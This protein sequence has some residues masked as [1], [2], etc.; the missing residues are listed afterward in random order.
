MVLLVHLRTLY[1]RHQARRLQREIDEH[2]QAL[3]AANRRLDELASTDGLTGVYNRRRFMELVRKLCEQSPEG[4]ACMALFDLDRFKLINDTH[5]HQ[6]GDTVICQAVEVIT[7]HCRHTDLI[8][9]YGGEEFVLCLPDTHLQQAHEIIERIRVELAGMTLIHDGSPVMVTAS[10]GIAQRQPHEA[11]ESWLSRTDKA[12]Y[13]AKRN[14][15][16]CCSLAS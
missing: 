13:Q 7:R 6:A 14:G 12:L 4:I 10:I 9:R 15:R 2:T 3:L 11:F 8:G 1:L 5:G 16:N